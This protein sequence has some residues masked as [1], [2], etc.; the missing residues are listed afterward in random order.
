MQTLLRVL[1]SH[2]WRAALGVLL[3]LVAV[4]EFGDT[5]LEQWLGAEIGAAH[6]V[7][8]LGIDQLVRGIASLLE[9]QQK[10]LGRE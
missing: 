10:F 4:M 6:G 8:I 2:V 3:V 7:M 9:A 5:R 1:R